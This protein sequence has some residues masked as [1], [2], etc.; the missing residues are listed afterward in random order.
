MSVDSADL[1]NARLTQVPES[2][3]IEAKK[4]ALTRQVPKWDLLVRC[5][6]SEGEV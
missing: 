5:V 4:R 6:V 3:T 2:S 1:V